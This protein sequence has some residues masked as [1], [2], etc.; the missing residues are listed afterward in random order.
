METMKRE[1]GLAILFSVLFIILLTLLSDSAQAIKPPET[2]SLECEVTYFGKKKS[3]VQL[4]LYEENN[5]KKEVVSNG[6]GKVK[7]SLEPGKYYTIKVSEEGFTDKKIQVNTS[8]LENFKKVKNVHVELGMVMQ[9]DVGGENY[10]DDLDFP[11]AVL[12]L[13]EKKQCFQY[14]SE[15][16]LAMQELEYNEQMRL[17]AQKYRKIVTRRKIANF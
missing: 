12:E 11:F 6:K 7:F 5:V 10:H 3:G 8:D 9:E 13:N 17:L 15:Y 2:L 16:A 4:K 1:S 14:D